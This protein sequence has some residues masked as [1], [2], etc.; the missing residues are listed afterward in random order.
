MNLRLFMTNSLTFLYDF[1]TG[2]PAGK[3]HSPCCACL[4]NYV[5]EDMQDQ[6]AFTY[7][8]L[9]VCVSMCWAHITYQ[10]IYLATDKVHKQ[11]SAIGVEQ[12]VRNMLIEVE[13]DV[14]ECVSSMFYAT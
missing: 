13:I 12:L 1:V 14:C 5:L 8:F 2:L 11:V 6:L 9:L 3:C 4:H 10:Y 7:I